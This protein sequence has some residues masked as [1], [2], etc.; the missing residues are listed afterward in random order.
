MIALLDNSIKVYIFG[1][2][3]YVYP[4]EQTRQLGDVMENTDDKTLT[5][6]DIIMDIDFDDIFRKET[7]YEQY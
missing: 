1:I 2:V 4:L 7:R 3:Y 6:F 5:R